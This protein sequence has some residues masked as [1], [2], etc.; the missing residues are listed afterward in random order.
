MKNKFNLKITS[1]NKIV[2]LKNNVF[3]SR[4]FFP[5]FFFFY[6]V[7]YLSSELSINFLEKNK[8]HTK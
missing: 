2:L 1:K 6:T 3:L 8:E 4:D 5:I 7:S